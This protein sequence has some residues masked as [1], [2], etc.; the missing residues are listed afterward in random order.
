MRPEFRQRALKLSFAALG[1]VV[2]LCEMCPAQGF[3]LEEPPSAPDIR[4]NWQQPPTDIVEA[5]YNFQL[6]AGKASDMRCY[7]LRNGPMSVLTPV[8][9][10]DGAEREVIFSGRLAPCRS[11]DACDWPD[12]IYKPGPGKV[13]EMRVGFGINADEY[14][15]R[16][17]LLVAHR[18]A[19]SQAN[20]FPPLWTIVK[21]A[22]VNTIEETIHI[23]LAVGSITKDEKLTYAFQVVEREGRGEYR[24]HQ[25]TRF[26]EPGL[27]IRWTA[28]ETKQ[29]QNELVVRMQ[30]KVVQVASKRPF[31]LDIVAPEFERSDVAK[32]EILDG[33]DVVLETTAPAY[34]PKTDL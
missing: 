7:R 8:K 18:A 12:G 6:Q 4:P 20:K 27:S 10:Q 17:E 11:N 30:Q 24:I 2:T 34:L 14:V 26:N 3:G 13:G 22:V 5:G 9:W 21:V 23:G 1:L 32:L 16:P 15:D 19:A 28:T 33:D 29:F 31:A 25:G